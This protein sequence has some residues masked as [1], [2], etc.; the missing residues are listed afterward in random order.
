MYNFFS[1]LALNL[2]LWMY[3]VSKN[4]TDVAHYNF[5]AHRPILVIFDRDV[6]ESMILN[7]DLFVHL[8]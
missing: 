3:R 4:N 8:S 1:L 7:G 5:N 2:T 6:A